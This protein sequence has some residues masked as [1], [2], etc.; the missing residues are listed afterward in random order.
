MFSAPCFRSPTCSAELNFD[1]IAANSVAEYQGG[2]C[3]SFLCRQRRAAER[4]AVDRDKLQRRGRGQVGVL[5]DT[6]ATCCFPHNASPGFR[7]T[8][9]TP[10]DPSLARLAAKFT[11]FL[12]RR[13]PRQEPLVSAC[14]PVDGDKPMQI[15]Y[16]S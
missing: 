7:V 14:P 6:I 12:G 1:D 2:C 15:Q 4:S 5:D 11:I 9:K 8:P 13:P 3:C 10:T 16:K